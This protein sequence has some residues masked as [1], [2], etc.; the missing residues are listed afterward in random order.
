MRSFVSVLVCGTVCAALSFLQ[1]AE[2][3]YMYLDSDGDGLSTSN[4]TLRVPGTT[5]VDIWLSTNRNRDGSTATC[6]S[7]QALTLN[8]YE[9]LLRAIDGTVA[10][11]PYT[12]NQ[13]VLGISLGLTTTPT[14]HRAGYIGGSTLAAGTYQL[15]SVNVFVISGRPRIEIAAQDSN[16]GFATAFGSLC[17]GSD[18][19]NT[20]KL[21]QDWSDIAGLAEAST[22]VLT[23][24]TFDAF[25]PSI[26]SGWSSTGSP[27]W[28]IGACGYWL[29]NYSARG[30]G[31][32]C[33]YATGADNAFFL[34][35]PA[36]VSEY[37]S[38][39]LSFVE[40]HS[41]VFG[42]V[43]SYGY[44]A[45]PD[46]NSLTG[47]GNEELRDDSYGWVRK[48]GSTIPNYLQNNCYLKPVFGLQT[49]TASPTTYG[50]W[51]AWIDSVQIYGTR[52][53][54]LIVT[55]A[56]V[57]P[58]AGATKLL[59]GDSC[60]VRFTVRNV[61][62]QPSGA[63]SS[64]VWLHRTGA[65]VEV[66]I[67]DHSSLAPGDTMPTT[68]TGLQVATA[69][70]Y[71]LHVQ[72]DY[73]TFV[74]ESA[75]NDGPEQN[76]AFPQGAP[77]TYIWTTPNRDLVVTA[78]TVSNANPS[79][80]DTIVATASLKNQGTD[81]CGATLLGFYKSIGATPT[82]LTTPTQTAGIPALA[83]GASATATFKI[84]SLAII[85]DTL[86]VLADRTGIV[87]E[88]NAG[89]TGEQN[90]A[91]GP[92]FVNWA[93]GVF[94]VHGY[95]VYSDSTN[96]GVGTNVPCS[97]V[98]V[99][100]QDGAGDDSLLATGFINGSDG[101]YQIG[102]IANLDAT[103]EPGGDAVLDV[104]VR[105]V[106]ETSEGCW[107][108]NFLDWPI[109]TVKKGD[110]DSTWYVDTRVVPNMPNRTYEFGLQSVT[111]YPHRSAAHILDRIQRVWQYFSFTYRDIY[112][113][114]GPI[115]ARWKVGYTHPTEYKPVSRVIYINGQLNKE[116]FQ[117]DEWNNWSIAH[118]YGHHLLWK[119][120]GLPVWAESLGTHYA[121][122]PCNSLYEAWSEGFAD[123]IGHH[124]AGYGAPSSIAEIGG[125]NPDGTTS[126]LRMDLETGAIQEFGLTPS[127]SYNDNDSGPLFEFA[128]ASLL[129]DVGDNVPDNPNGDE[130]SD[131][132]W[133]GWGAAWQVPLK[134][135]SG[136]ENVCRYEKALLSWWCCDATARQQQL[137]V[138]GEHGVV[139]DAAWVPT[140][141]T[142][143]S[144]GQELRL[145]R[146][147][148]NPFNP[149][150]AIR[151]D[152]P[153]GKAERATL[154]VFDVNGRRVKTLYNEIKTGGG[155]LVVW[156]G[157][158]ERGAVVSSGIYFCQLN[159]RGQRRTQR[160]TL[161][162]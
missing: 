63:F 104:Y 59:T 23:V 101:S 39:S 122:A 50:C 52:R 7:G 140:A 26:P 156:D 102:P 21:G 42:D 62:D 27:S 137:A 105:W 71:E 16:G 100:H 82:T 161:L 19:D 132:Y 14:T 83:A 20:L 130:Y 6:P 107:D 113:S 148:P 28:A 133:G 103:P 74:T 48:T 8:S 45:G 106:F 129:W 85:T 111:D 147:F 53:P 135:V 143:A 118:E 124:H 3:Q 46:P 13:P 127:F 57:S 95:F 138:F 91:A 10:W 136:I 2:A 98:E 72:T 112:G 125:R 120:G 139:C 5:R 126:R 30:H 134:H 121:G 35:S 43:F 37:E 41:L 162:K 77:I 55:K 80:G 86:Y 69:A 58:K 96:N 44:L 49:F 141:V 153:V 151:F 158:D 97:R 84:A 108:A 64:R 54:D 146:S 47:K 70:T 24:Q 15:G 12:N 157:T 4:D 60:T 61:G 75:T 149:R 22:S 115:T 145:H 160:V 87:V 38:Y 34:A 9:F 40:N 150:T 154:A 123:V 31:N 99:W 144:A 93:S 32:C 92:A 155:H 159:F 79:L 116:N 66:G 68:F 65:D 142:E 25:P 110:L 76:N 114:P 56:S 152:L 29:G 109:V 18:E 1:N 67:F 128:V 11:G 94:T 73:Y 51:G 81:P 33:T 88:T 89:G 117:P 17:V 131:N 90:N 119:L 78:F 36:Y